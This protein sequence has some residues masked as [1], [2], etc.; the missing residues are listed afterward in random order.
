[1]K[2]PQYT[3]EKIADC[4]KSVKDVIELNRKVT[5][6]YGDLLFSFE[7]IE[8]AMYEDIE[9]YLRNQED[10]M[11]KTVLAEKRKEKVDYSSAS[12]RMIA[13]QKIMR[14]SKI[15]QIHSGEIP[16]WDD[17]KFRITKFWEKHRAK[18]IKEGKILKEKIQ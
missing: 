2:S 12:A 9:K 17:Y 18:L 3:P 15:F 8:L 13:R 7:V 16:R 1:M 11:L 10:T 6:N 14:E 4:I 5:K